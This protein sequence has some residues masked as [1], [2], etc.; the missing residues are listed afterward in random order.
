[1]TQPPQ[2]LILWSW[3]AKKSRKWTEYETSQSQAIETAFQSELDACELSTSLIVFDPRCRWLACQYFGQNAPERHVRRI[4]G[5]TV[6]GSWKSVLTLPNSSASSSLSSQDCS[7]CLIELVDFTNQQPLY[8]TPCKHSYHRSCLERWLQNSNKCPYCKVNIVDHRPGFQPNGVMVITADTVAC[9]GHPN[10][11]TFLLLWNLEGGVQDERHPHPGKRFSGVEREA[12][13][14]TSK[15]GTKIL[16]KMVQA[17]Y[18]RH[19]FGV[20][21][22]L[23]SSVVGDSIIYSI[24][25][26]TSRDGGPHG[27]PCPNYLDDVEKEL[28]QVL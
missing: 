2:P 13:L 27:Y 19:M 3:K 24:H 6:E 14:P 26:K 15:A 4:E 9:A 11:C 8:T 20:G 18:Q 25:L 23:S 7:I 5:H 17:F 21:Q 22:S 16:R 10:D 12:Y 28:D 1:M